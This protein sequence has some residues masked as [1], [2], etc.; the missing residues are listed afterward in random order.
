MLSAVEQQKLEFFK[1]KIEPVLVKHC[2]E[3]HSHEADEIGGSLR[4]DS[5][6]EMRIGG[7]TGPAIVP[8]DT[9]A[10]LLIKA[11]RHDDL[12]MPPT[13]RLP[14]SV[15]AD[16][17]TWVAS[18]AI[19]P[20]EKRISDSEP[21]Y[22]EA[23]EYW[24]FQPVDSFPPLPTIDND[25]AVLSPVDF[26]IEEKL[27]LLKLRS[28]P[29]A[30]RRELIRRLYFDLLGL[31]PTIDD[32]DSFLNDPAPDAYERLVDRL[33]ASPRYGEKWA[34]HWLDVVRFAETEGFEYDRLL[35]GAWRFRDYVI[36]SFNNDKPYDQFLTEQIAGDE[37]DSDN[38]IYRVA[39]GF[40][41]LG[42]VRRNAGNQKVA[43]SRNEVLT[44]RTDIIG[45]AILGIT[46]GCARCHD[47]KFDP[48]TQR[49]YYQLQAFFAATE[50]DNVIVAD[51]TRRRLWREQTKA[52]DEQVANLKQLIANQSGKTEEE[53]RQ[54]IEQLESARPA[55]L[56][57][58]CSIKNDGSHDSIRLLRRG[59]PDLPGPT[60]GMSPPAVL[61]S[62]R[63][64]ES[65]SNLQ[66]ENPKTLL[67]GWL[68]SD[69]NPLTAR[70]L[71]NRIWQYHF[72]RG[73]VA[74]AN[75]FGTNGA[76][77]SHSELLDYLTHFFIQNE[78]SL[79]RLHRVIL[80]SRTYRQS[81][82]SP[83]EKIGKRVD[84]ENRYLWK[85]SRRRLSSEEIRDA[86]LAVSGRLTSKMFGE[87]IMVPVDKELIDQLYKPSQWQITDQPSE[88]FRRSVYL[89]AKRNLRLPFMEVFDQP[90]AL[91]SCALREQST[92][93]P[94]ALE[95]L[96]GRLS[97]QL[98]L[99]LANRLRREAGQS[100]IEQV[101]L[102]Y[103]LA[104]GRPPTESELALSV[105]FINEV[106]L[107][108]FSLAMFNLNAFL[109]V[110]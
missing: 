108:E 15:V 30:S 79:K 83:N 91:T 93:A 13:G 8:G 7:D 4:M 46:I 44:E 82:T 57:M 102:A 32:I 94:Q 39:A 48:I 50:E 54:K 58:L 75:D 89:L 70:V 35:R 69:K 16:F 66:A 29:L 73:I 3:C 76:R 1:T 56:P 85:F 90:P 105:R 104:S 53:T 61:I 20:R 42:S 43:S 98:A 100:P 17:E 2:F 22:E 84:P 6:E 97:N 106:S 109:Y 60:V 103:E 67:A 80:L 9:K 40:H 38:E 78:W 64:I 34:Q 77:P 101:R 28:A 92:H 63:S 99:E 86:M 36:S 27:E 72:G 107:Q 5:R 24:A 95:L 47:H 11:I 71:V 68:S 26:F 31:P 62:D 41:R 51:E 96:N 18:G 14:D 52:I 65:E 87:S 88:H 37:L 23:R 12:E 21:D 74:T 59:D 110:N 45:S 81:S 49:D 33:L 55:P 19:D 25:A 10:S